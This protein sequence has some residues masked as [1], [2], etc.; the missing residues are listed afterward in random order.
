MTHAVVTIEIDPQTRVDLALPLNIPSQALADAI[1]KAQ[2]V[3]KGGKKN[4]SLIV[5]TEGGLVRI[6]SQSTLGDASVLDGFILQLSQEKSA[7]PSR[8]IKR[9]ACLETETGQM[10]AL[11]ADSMLIGRKDT[12]RGIL[13]DI[14]L[15]PLDLRR[16]VTRKHAVLEKKKKQWTLTD[17]GS[18]NGTWLNGHKLEVHQ[19]YPLQDGDEIV[20]GRNGIVLKFLNQK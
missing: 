7:S 16:I 2:E 12:K 13:V 5:R 11:D 6:P 18:A 9:N 20:F 3:D 4:Y 19:S 8:K 14:D 1:A 10:F 15:S 17:L